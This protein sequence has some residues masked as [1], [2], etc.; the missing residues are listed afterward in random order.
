[1]RCSGIYIAHQHTF[2]SQFC[3]VV[4]GEIRVTRRAPQGTEGLAAD[5]EQEVSLLRVGGSFGGRALL[6]GI[7]DEDLNSLLF[8]T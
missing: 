8:T 1:M 2:R 4:A 6:T 7:D 3:V 5:Q